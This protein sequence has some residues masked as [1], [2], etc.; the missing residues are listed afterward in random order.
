MD[1]NWPD[2]PWLAYNFLE[3]PW[4]LI[5]LI[6]GIGACVLFVGLRQGRANLQQGGLAGLGVALVIF[7]IAWFVETDR[8]AIMRQTRRLVVAA[9]AQP[10]DLDTFI[11]LSDPTLKLGDRDRHNLIELAQSTRKLVRVTSAIVMDLNATVTRP[12]KGKSLL[13][14]TGNAAYLKENFEVSYG[15]RLLLRW[16][17]IG[18]KWV[19]MDVEKLTINGMDVDT[20]L[21]AIR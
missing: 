21:R 12:R 13:A 2:P 16:E 10:L 6:G 18:G 15:A 3:S 20:A 1:T 19:V 5:I 4:K 9:R 14:V 8:E 11:A 7:A 17:Q